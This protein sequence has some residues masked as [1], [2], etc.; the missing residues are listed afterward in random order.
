MAKTWQHFRSEPGARGCVKSGGPPLSTCS[1]L[2]LSRGPSG[3]RRW[4]EGQP[5]PNQPRVGWEELCSE[6][7]LRA[8]AHAGGNQEVSCLR[9]LDSRLPRVPVSYNTVCGTTLWHSRMG[10]AQMRARGA[11]GPSASIRRLAGQLTRTSPG[12]WRRWR[13]THTVLSLDRYL[14]AFLGLS[15]PCG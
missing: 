2:R 5:C 9:L 13:G 10:L 8:L 11:T 1:P 15:E 3:P 7:A 4:N 14:A 6:A 12:L